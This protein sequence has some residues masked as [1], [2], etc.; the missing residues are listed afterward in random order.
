MGFQFHVLNL[1]A[2]HDDAPGIA[3]FASGG[4]I[5][6]EAAPYPEFSVAVAFEPEPAKVNG[7]IQ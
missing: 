6:Q 3:F 4:E 7:I 5:K 1:S 2:E